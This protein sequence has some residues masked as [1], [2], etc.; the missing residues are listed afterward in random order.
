MT[1][2]IARSEKIG[3]ASAPK[4]SADRVKAFHLRKLAQR[5]RRLSIY[6]SEREFHCLHEL[7]GHFDKTASIITGACIRDAWQRV[8]ANK[9][10]TGS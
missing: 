2:D 1:D 8:I 3:A 7:M 5:Q 6:V 10:T 4:S 9:Q